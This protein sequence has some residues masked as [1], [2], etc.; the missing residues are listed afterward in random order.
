[1]TAPA[2]TVAVAAEFAA[3]DADA[4]KARIHALFD[5]IDTDGSFQISRKELAAKLRA[6][7]EL[8]A[9]LGFADTSIPQVVRVMRM[10]EDTG[11]ID[12]DVN[13]HI[14]RDEF[15]TVLL[16]DR[17]EAA[18]EATERAAGARIAADEPAVTATATL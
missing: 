5:S 11:E 17:A 8:E 18:K 6:D 4:M 14:T 3:E 9:L 15:E 1:V 7:G 16:A 13:S 10:L 2:E 12:Q